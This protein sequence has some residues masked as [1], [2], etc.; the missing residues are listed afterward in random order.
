MNSEFRFYKEN[1]KCHDLYKDNHKFQTYTF[2]TEKLRRYSTKGIY[3]MT[4]HEVIE[5]MDQFVDPSD[6]DIDLPNSIHIYQ[7]AEKIRK[8]QPDNHELQ[9]CGLMHDLGKI[10]YKFGE[11]SWNIVGDTFVVGC[12]Y[13]KSIV[14]YDSLRENPD[15]NN[16]KY[17]TKFGVYEEKCGIENLKLSFGH[18]EYL[19]LVLRRN[20]NHK[21]S[22]KYLNIIR[23]HSFYSWHSEGEYRRFMIESDFKIL[24]DVQEFNKYDLYSK[25]NEDKIGDDVKE[26]YRRLIDEYF[27]GSLVW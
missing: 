25:E 14:Y 11:P 13:P 7:T 4:I 10:L 21:L 16:P 23:Y 27:P 3:E 6:P 9:L 26:Y 2:V 15:F 5:A 20:R 17:N 22:D 1:S 8:D 19:Y 24:E 18:D 12:E